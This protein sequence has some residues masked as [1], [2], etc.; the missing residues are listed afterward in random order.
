MALPLCVFIGLK[1]LNLV[2]ARHR[3]FV[4]YL[5]SLWFS[6]SFNK[7][8]ASCLGSETY[9]C[10]VILSTHGIVDLE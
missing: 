1:Y 4:S 7:G 2:C 10:R 6:I 3:N 9:I 5:F 8:K